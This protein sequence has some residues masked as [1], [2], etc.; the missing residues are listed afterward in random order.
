MD[1]ALVHLAVLVH[2][3]HVD[4]TFWLWDSRVA[5][6][7]EGLEMEAAVGIAVGYT[8]LAKQCSCL[9]LKD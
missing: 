1:S 6:E 3:V 7:V 4:V 2:G 5:C 9:F 8:W